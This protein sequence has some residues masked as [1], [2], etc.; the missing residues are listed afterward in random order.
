MAASSAHPLYTP[1]PV[2]SLTVCFSSFSGPQA[3]I[4]TV[5]MSGGHRVGTLWG[6]NDLFQKV[7]GK[8]SYK[9]FLRPHCSSW[10]LRP[11]AH[12]HQNRLLEPSLKR[13]GG[14][15]GAV[16]ATLEAQL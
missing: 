12:G 11:T 4:D 7:L 9:A 1:N 6:R 8:G 2:L 10:I 16:E 13:P 3:L 15:G 14:G 5:C